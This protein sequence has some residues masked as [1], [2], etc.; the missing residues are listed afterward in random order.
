MNHNALIMLGGMC[1]G[2]DG[3]LHKDD[4]SIVPFLHIVAAEGEGS[5]RA[6]GGQVPV[7]Q[8]RALGREAEQDDAY[9]VESSHG[10]KG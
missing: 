7:V 8:R 1:G 4:G 2:V 9:V 6:A 10:M 3:G 5:T